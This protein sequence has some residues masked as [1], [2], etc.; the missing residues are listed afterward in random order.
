MERLAEVLVLYRDSLRYTLHNVSD[1]HGDTHVGGAPVD[2]RECGVAAAVWSFGCLV[3]I[4]V[5]WW[6]EAVFGPAR[7]KN[8]S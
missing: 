3:L 2:V 8:V 6:D 5:V 4:E 1:A 7:S